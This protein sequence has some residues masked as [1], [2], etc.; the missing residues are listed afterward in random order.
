L[1]VSIEAKIDIDPVIRSIESMMCIDIVVFEITGLVMTMDVKATVIADI[2]VTNLNALVT[3]VSTTSLHETV[4]TTAADPAAVQW[5]HV[6]HSVLI[7]AVNLHTAGL[8]VPANGAA[9]TMNVIIAVDL[10]D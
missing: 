9:G 3:A 1:P 2:I 6:G 10:T 8:A 4:I 5:T 7:S